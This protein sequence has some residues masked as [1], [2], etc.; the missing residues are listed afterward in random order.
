[1]KRLPLLLGACLA[2]LAACA[3]DTGGTAPPSQAKSTPKPAPKP[4]PPPVSAETLAR[5]DADF[6]P[7][8]PGKP[9]SRREHHAQQP[10]V[11]S[12]RLARHEV[13][14]RDW[15]EVMGSN[16]SRDDSDPA[17]PVTNVS[18]HD[19]HRFI[20]RLNEAKGAAVYRLPTAEEWELGCRAG[21]TGHV[22]MQASD[23]ALAP[24]AWYGENSGGHTHPVGTKKPNAFGLYDILG[25]VAEWCETAEDPKAENVMRVNAG[26]HFDD[27]NL[28]GQD[29]STTSWLA[30]DGRE[31]WTGFRL[32]KGD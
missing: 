4:T 23:K 15:T 18:W 10:P 30:E 5:I 7:I 2:L 17:L 6:V 14:Q 26:G 13:T 11:A 25:N 31:K 1:M 12:F 9:A 24:Y 32:A 16:P 20:D 21:A 27:L 19:A 8:P 28:T 29:C 22:P 3:T